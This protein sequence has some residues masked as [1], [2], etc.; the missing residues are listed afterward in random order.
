MKIIGIT[1]QTGAGKSTVCRELQKLGFYHI[2]ADLVARELTEKNSPVIPLLCS[3][4]GEDILNTDG[5]VNRKVL[6]KRAFSSNENTLLL[7]SI[8]HPA[9]TEKIREIIKE[10]KAQNCK[11]VLIDAIALFESGE[12]ELCDFTVSVV[13][14]TEIRL[15]RITERD[16]ISREEAML[17]INAQKDE[18]FYRKNA[19]FVIENYPPHGLS[20]QIK[21]IFKDE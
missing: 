3:A 19:D 11:A 21:R 6:A 2:D 13:A 16:N 5:S 14:P 9:V 12:N 20:E 10:Q 7:N 17:R 18:A 15:K 4:F 1:G 8:T